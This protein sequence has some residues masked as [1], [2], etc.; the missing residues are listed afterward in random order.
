MDVVDRD[1]KLVGV[2]E[3]E[4]EN[5]VRWRP[6]IHCGQ[7]IR[8]QLK[9]DKQVEQQ[10]QTICLSFLAVSDGQRQGSLLLLLQ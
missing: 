8:E 6:M 2:R 10:T 5:R 4:A 7:Q 1:V 9:E 3:E